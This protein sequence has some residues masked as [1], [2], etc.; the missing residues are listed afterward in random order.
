M[1]LYGGHY[2]PYATRCRALVYAKGIDIEILDTD[3]M[4][5]GDWQPQSLTGK[6]PF[7]LTGNQAIPESGVICEFLE[8][9]FPETP[10]LPANAEDR[11]LARA[12]VA[13]AEDQILKKSMALMALLKPGTTASK[14]A[15]LDDLRQGL[16]LFDAY[17][18][19]HPQAPGGTD[20]GWAD[21]MAVPALL[22]VQ[23]MGRL[24]GADSI[25]EEF[26]TIKDYWSQIG[27]HPVAA[28]ITAEMSDAVQR[29]LGKKS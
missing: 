19:K 8:E 9:K 2:C 24:V 14:D 28:K 23:L 29:R 12:A 7:L 15:L 10:L 5:A 6:T 18:A 17:L 13:L 16:Q 27:S 25:L 4:D 22:S 1:K 26:G 11:A 20:F 21:C 3:V